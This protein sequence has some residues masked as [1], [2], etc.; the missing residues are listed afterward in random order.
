MMSKILLLALALSTFGAGALAADKSP[1]GLREVFEAHEKALNAHDLS[2]LMKLYAPGEQAV[3]MGT[4]PAERWV[5][6]AQIEDAYRHFFEDFDA[7]T[8]QRDCPW[9]VSDLGGD[10]GWLSATCTYQDSLKGA[11]RTFA[12]NVSAV[13]QKM[14]GAWKLR[15]MHYSNPTAP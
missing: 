4:I 10:V 2:G 8:V 13:L 15:A 7:G 6:S 11:S 1:A 3:V 5:G 12:L 14:D 9:V